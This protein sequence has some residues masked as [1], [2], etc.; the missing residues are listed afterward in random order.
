MN[1]LLL[2]SWG[3]NQRVIVGR[4][5][6]QTWANRN[7]QVTGLDA[8]RQL[9]IQANANIARI[10]GVVVVKGV[11]ESKRIAHREIPVFSKFLQGLR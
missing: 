9:G 4:H 8:C 5:F 2:G 11:L 6:S 3:F 10:L 1:Q 7:D